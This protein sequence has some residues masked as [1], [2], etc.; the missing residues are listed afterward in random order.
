MRDRRK[1]FTTLVVGRT[2][3]LGYLQ[4]ATYACAPL[5]AITSS[6]FN[7]ALHGN[8]KA[9]VHVQMREAPEGMGPEERK[10]P[11]LPTTLLLH[12]GG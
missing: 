10:S 11:L 1:L 2:P 3:P 8:G 6:R 12:L 4:K 5:A 7:N 9:L